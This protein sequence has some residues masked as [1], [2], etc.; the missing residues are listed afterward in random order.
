MR[1]FQAGG[2]RRILQGVPVLEEKRG[3]RGLPSPAGARDVLAPFLPRPALGAKKSELESATHNTFP[4]TSG[5][6]QVRQSAVRIAART[7]APR[8]FWSRS[9]LLLPVEIGT[10]LSSRLAIKVLRISPNMLI[11]R[12]PRIQVTQQ[13]MMLTPWCF[14]ERD[15]IIWIKFQVR[16][17][18]KRLDMMNL[19]M[20]ALMTT[21]HARRLTPQVL[22]RHSRPF[23]AP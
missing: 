8:L 10:N 13:Q 2:S 9:H 7:G 21:G 5:V 12:V 17:Q 15:Q 19:Q 6:A 3:Y 4:K 16:V 1:P 11:I 18:M 23:G 20:F 22:M 14:T